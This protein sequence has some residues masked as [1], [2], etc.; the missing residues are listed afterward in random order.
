M[1]DSLK[2]KE[3]VQKLSVLFIFHPRRG[4]RYCQFWTKTLTGI[5]ELIWR[6]VLKYVA[7]ILADVFCLAPCIRRNGA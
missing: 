4:K 1:P 6:A 2:F 3:K 5:W 7:D